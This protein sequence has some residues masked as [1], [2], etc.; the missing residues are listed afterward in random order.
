MAE[1]T[2][3][4]QYLRPKF[5]FSNFLCSRDQFF[6]IPRKLFYSFQTLFRTLLEVLHRFLNFKKDLRNINVCNLTDSVVTEC[7]GISIHHHDYKRSQASLRSIRFGRAMQR[8]GDA[9]VASYGAAITIHDD[10]P[11]V[12]ENAT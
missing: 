7:A 12:F 8:N 1:S 10:A 5:M 4:I 6:V 3:V 11:R 9:T 2:Y